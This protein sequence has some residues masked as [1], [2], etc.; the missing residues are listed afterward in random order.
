M[1]KMPERGSKVIRIGAR[2]S[3]LSRVQANDILGRLSKIA[4][5]FRFELIVVRTS[6]D[7]D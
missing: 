3:Q 6:G 7:I 5:E 2:G 1:K 4:P